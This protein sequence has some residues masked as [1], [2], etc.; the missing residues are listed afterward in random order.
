[1]ATSSDS[2]SFYFFDFDDNI[3]FLT[4]RILILNTVTG[5]PRPVSTGE[6]ANIESLLGKPGPWQDYAMF[7]GSFRNFRDIPEDELEPGQKQHFVSD[8][9]AAVCAD[10]DSWKAPAWDL[11]V[12]A[13]DKQRP[14]SIVTARGHSP[15]T[16]K[17]GVRVLVDQGLIPR[18]PNYLSVFPVTNDD[19]RREQLDDPDLVVTTPALKKR[20]IMQTVERALEQY[21]HEPKH[22]FGMSDDDPKNVH[23]IISAMVE[24]KKKYLD[25][26]FFVI[27]THM[28]EKVK[29]EV[30]PVDFPVTGRPGHVLAE[31]GT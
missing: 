17:A 16:L 2:V 28:G 7:N 26:R 1:M 18:E 14:V 6:F 23:L 11:F 29:L 25:K 15:A 9:E 8:V 31:P 19:V 3:M 20:A 30:F 12:H 10:G 27:N 22:R 21:G 4:T 5:E 13:C 24:C